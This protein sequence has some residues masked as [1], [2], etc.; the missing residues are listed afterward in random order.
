MVIAINHQHFTSSMLIALPRLVVLRQKLK[1]PLRNSDKIAW[2]NCHSRNHRVFLP[3]IFAGALDQNGG[4]ACAVGQ[5]AGC[6]DGGQ[7]IET[8]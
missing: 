6:S 8:A 5:P 2:Q 3:H 7:N 1:I 4:P